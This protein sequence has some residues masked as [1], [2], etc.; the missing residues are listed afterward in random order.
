MVCRWRGQT[1]TLISDSRGGRGP[2]PLEVTEQEPLTAKI[3]SE[4]ITEEDTATEHHLLLLPWEH[5]H[6]AAATAKYSGQC[7]EV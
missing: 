5:T 4:G 6:P 3:T 7:P 2:L 1:T